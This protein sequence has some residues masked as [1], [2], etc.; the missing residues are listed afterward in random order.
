MINLY[1][2]TIEGSY[3]PL[4]CYP[5]I[6]EKRN[7]IAKKLIEGG[8]EARPFLSGSLGRQPMYYDRYGEKELPNCDLIMEKGLY[9][10]NGASLKEAEIKYICDIIKEVIND[11]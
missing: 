2:N 10:P 3:T 8:I 11:S 5:I 7:S 6:H 9:V 1:D 4:F